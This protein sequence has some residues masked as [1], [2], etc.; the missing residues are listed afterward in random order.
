MPEISRLVDTTILVDFLRGNKAAR[1]WIESFAAGELSVSVITAAELVAGCRNRKEQKVVEE[2]LAVYP[3]IWISSMISA[4]AWDWYRR[5]HLSHGIGFLDCLVGAS[6]HHHGLMVC[7][8]N[9]RHFRP[10]PHL[11]VERPY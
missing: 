4:S 10:F 5:F 2:E 7:T 1:T 3:I 8:L 11:R 6:A 9:E